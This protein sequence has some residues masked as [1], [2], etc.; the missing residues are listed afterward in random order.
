MKELSWIALGVAV[1]VVLAMMTKTWEPFALELV[2]NTNMQRTDA[3]K[4]S[5]YAQVTNNV[6]PP[7]DLGLPP[8]SGIETSFRVN[9][10]NSFVPT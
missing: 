4:D 9:M 8:L 1:I 3:N 10:F 7:S 5:S 6:K 2:D